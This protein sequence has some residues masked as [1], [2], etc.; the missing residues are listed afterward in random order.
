MY[1]QI[2]I[3]RDIAMLGDLVA[4]T[5]DEFRLVSTR[6][7]IVA[8]GIGVNFGITIALGFLVG[9]FLSASVFLQFTLENLRYFAV[10]KALGAHTRTL[11]GMVITQAMV[12]GAALPRDDIPPG[13]VWRRQI[14]RHEVQ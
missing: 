1:Q 13:V 9:L 5:P 11:V 3:Q 6:F 2:Q 14:A 4:Y 10:L 7:I 8:T 12:V